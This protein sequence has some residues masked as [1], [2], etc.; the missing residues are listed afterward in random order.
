MSQ[1]L[2]DTHVWVWSFNAKERLSPE[3][4]AIL[5]VATSVT[6]SAI[7]LYEIGQKVRLGK[8]PEMASSVATLASMAREQGVEILD[9][10]PEIS[11]SAGVLSW[12]HRDPFDRIIGATARAHGLPLLSADIAFDGLAPMSGWAGRVW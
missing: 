10:T 1:V 4:T 7:T 12:G 6:I 11:L 9:V 3:A 5:T 2:L 8:W